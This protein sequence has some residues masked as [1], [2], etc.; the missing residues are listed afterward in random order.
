MAEGVTGVT[1][2][3]GLEAGLPARRTRTKVATMWLGEVQ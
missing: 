2:A 1:T 3:Q